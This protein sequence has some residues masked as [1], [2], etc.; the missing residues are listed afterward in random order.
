MRDIQ[1]N[2][3]QN[4]KGYNKNGINGGKTTALYP[5]NASLFSLNLCLTNNTVH[6]P[7]NMFSHNEPYSPK[8]RSEHNPLSLSLSLSL[9]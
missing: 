6:L 9:G 5:N 2:N 8:I 3:L 7:H 1:Y 4:D